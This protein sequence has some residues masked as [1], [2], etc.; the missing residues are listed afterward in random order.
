MEGRGGNYWERWSRRR[1]RRSFI[2]GSSAAAI[3]AAA[4]G[5]VGC[6]DDDSGGTT[7]AAGGTTQASPA[8]EKVKLGGEL[9]IS[10]GLEPSSLDPHTGNSGGDNYFY[11]DMFDVLIQRDKDNKLDGSLSLAEKWEVVDPQNLTLHLRKGVTFHD[12]TPFNADVVKWNIQRVQDPATKSVARPTFI[13]VDTVETPDDSTVKL[14]LKE[15]NAALLTLLSGR[16]GVMVSRTA[17][18]KY[19]DQFRSHP[20]GTG[21]FAFEEWTPAAQVR[22]KKNPTYWGKDAQGNALPYLDRVTMKIITDSNTA[23]AALQT[24]DVQMGGIDP[25][26]LDQAKAI[27]GLQ[28]IQKD[29]TGISSV[30]VINKRAPGGDDLNFRKA[31]MYAVDPA[32]AKKAIFFDQAI[33]AKGAHWPPG[34]FAYQDI[35]T[36]PTYDVNKAKD[37][38]SKAKVDLNTEYQ[39]ISWDSRTI[40]QQGELY[41]E[42]LRKIG[43][44]TKQTTMAVGPATNEAFSGTTFTIY[45]TS[46]SLYVDPDQAAS[47]IYDKDAT[48]NTGKTQTPEIL[49]LISD[50]RKEY[51]TEK[52]K[53]IYKDL[54]TA[55]LDDAWH[56]P[57]LYSIAFLGLAKNVKGTDLVFSGDA[58]WRYKNLWL[59]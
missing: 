48:Y 46:W 44:K 43:I 4:L 55:I 36:H 59:A 15:P 52:R 50:G 2:V 51:D 54:A 1:S 19:G 6:G 17:V 45:P 26:D 23:F 42:A 14:K 22:M 24:G 12:G 37:F 35:A 32:A 9:K 29:G 47:G 7:P 18:E 31:I 49:K 53:A 27:P 38:L 25:K 34:T 5:L 33:I 56:V 30:M 20:V 41:A 13:N 10:Y 39:M 58:K 11:E 16:G 28:I 3:G 57:M 40:I 8:A 21:P